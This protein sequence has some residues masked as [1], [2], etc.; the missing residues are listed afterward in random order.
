[1][2]HV[3]RR[4]VGLGLSAALL[5]T[6][7]AGLLPAPA[8]AADPTGG[9]VAA[10][11]DWTVSRAPGG[12]L[13]TVDLDRPLPMKS[14][15]PTIVVDGETVG[16]ATQAADGKSLSVFTTD[17]E[18]ASAGKADAGWASQS[19][20]GDGTPS[21][22][23]SVPEVARAAAALETDPAA[24][25]SYDWTES[26]YKFGDQAIP[27]AAI[28]GIRGELEGK[29]YLPT[30]GGARP[31]VILLHGRHTSCYGPN[32]TNPLRWPCATAP[33]NELRKSIPS[34]AGYDGTARALASQGYSVVSISANAINSNDAELTADQGAQARGQLILDT[35]TMLDKATKGEPVVYYD[36]WQ[37]RDRTLDQALVDGTASYA[38]RADG[39]VGG[40]PE[41]DT[42]TAAGLV[43][44]FDLRT[45]G[46]MGHSRGGEGVTS[47]ATLNQ[48]LATP[49]AIKSILPL[50]PVDFARMTVP[51]VPMNVI[52]PY[53][54]GDVSNQQGQHMLD[55]SRYAFGDDVLRSGTWVMGS[56]HNFYN[57]VWT[58]G[59]YL[60]SV[61]DDWSNSTARR[62]EPTCGTDASVA[63]TSIRMTADEQYAQGTSYMTA[64]FRLTL[65][66]EQQFLPMFDGS[67]SV[68]AALNGEDVR[69]VATA[70]SSKR[71]TLASFEEATSLVR[72]FGTATANPCASMSGRTAP[73]SLPFCTTTMASSQLPHWTPATNGGNVPATPVTRMTWT[74][75]TGEVRVSV[76]VGKRNASGFERLSVKVAADETVTTGTDLTMTVVD[77]EG[78]TWTS[79]VSALNPYA[80]VRMPTST[81]SSAT[82]TLKK[83]VL[84]Q[85]NVPVAAL[86]AA[87]L[88]T[89][90]VREVRFTAAPGADALPTGGVY[91]SDLA[92]ETSSVGTAVIK[93]EPVIDVFAPGIDEG[94]GPGTVDLAVYLNQAAATP[95]SG[96]VSLLGATNGR[97]GIAMEK[98]TFAPGETCKVVTAPLQG[99]KATSSSNGTNIKYS[100][101]DVAGAVQ[102]K[103]AVGWLS[104]RED[105]GTTASAGPLPAYGTPGAVCAELAGVRA[106][107]AVATAATTVPGTDA[108]V[109]ATGFRAGEAVTF[110]GAGLA[111]V[112][113]TAD[114]AGAVSATM[115]VP[116]DVARGALAVTA[117]AAA[118]GRVATGALGVRDTSTTTLTVSPEVPALRQPVT[119][120]AT[121]GGGDATGTVTFR[122]GETVLGTADTVAGVASL[123]VPGFGA[124]AH[125][126]SA[127]FAQTAVSTSS[128]SAPVAFTLAKS[129]PTVALT[130]GAASGTFGSSAVT[131]DVAVGGAVGG[132][133]VEITFG[134]TT[135]SVALDES[136]HASYTLPDTLS[137]GSYAVTAQ[138]LGSADAEASTVASAPYEVKKVASTVALSLGARSATF[139]ASAVTASVAVTNAVGGD[140]RLTFG[141]RTVTVPV[142][143]SGRASYRLPATLPAGSYAV[144]AQYLGSADA[145]ASA[146]ASAPYTVARKAT[147]TAVKV[148]SSV[149]AGRKLSVVAS[150]SGAVAGTPVTGKLTVK[151]R[152]GASLT[153]TVTLPASGKVSLKVPTKARA[154]GRKLTVTVSFTATGSYASS[155]APART[156]RL[157]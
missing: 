131:A 107:G 64:W 63:A 91:L 54:D 90:D 121:V 13:V 41:L 31:T 106:G 22:A 111:P 78:V 37:Q 150:V 92:F 58:P 84:Q 139:G 27:L 93:T 156:V 154:Q 7:L 68:P 114:P 123:P 59:K 112:V 56:N 71:A 60:N 130:L 44:K 133:D 124:G 47:A 145:E 21:R 1:M 157:K 87:G 3:A 51:N 25:G 28:G 29:L 20:A 109:S 62:T 120:T 66:G 72:S 4:R 128:A 99:D 144:T 15:A 108:T 102:G 76:P 36:A 79:L 132:G 115:A 125:A 149:K 86:A 16:L 95:V 23:V 42:V 143:G 151:V 35:L 33:T 39:F 94:N 113:A 70:P 50:A 101:I 77:N 11:D 104:V 45:I 82:S 119:L 153:R 146:V 5:A 61:S 148:A 18:V 67:G 110:T 38:T 134:S 55:D 122:D 65:G 117:T 48:A 88:N 136:G 141:G 32:P 24:P 17:P 138:Y 73:Q 74:S 34:Y 100:V 69:T 96:Y 89:A 30:T 14:D 43:G 49:W 10:G 116:A 140:V 118:T 53:C 135:V 81:S 105:D 75:A 147:R 129:T 137:A 40:A 85:V 155:S 46:L 6:P 83:V 97:A 98:V 9:T 80:L 8:S 127:S 57:T 152:G 12:Y 103:K 2:R 126:L 142:D 19:V 26:I 52:L